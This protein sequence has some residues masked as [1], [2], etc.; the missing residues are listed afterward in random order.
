MPWGWSRTGGELTLFQAVGP[1]GS[2]KLSLCRSSPVHV[3]VRACRRRCAVVAD[4]TLEE[5]SGTVH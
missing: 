2:D 4:L 5:D 3:Q 1:V